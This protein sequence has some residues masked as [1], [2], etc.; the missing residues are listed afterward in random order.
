MMVTVST[1]DLVDASLCDTKTGRM[2]GADERVQRR[3]RGDVVTLHDKTRTSLSV[4]T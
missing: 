4:Q 2:V 1:K 3:R